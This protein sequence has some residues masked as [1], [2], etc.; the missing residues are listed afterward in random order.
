[1]KNRKLIDA[2]GY[3]DGRYIDMA[4]NSG[5]FGIAARI[6]RHWLPAAACLCAV[7]VLAAIIGTLP[8]G[9][10]GFIDDA[11]VAVSSG[12]T[13]A[14]TSEVYDNLGELLES[15]SD[16]DNH[17]GKGADGSSALRGENA[18]PSSDGGGK[19]AVSGGYAYHLGD[20]RVNISRLAGDATENVGSIAF[21]ADALYLCGERLALVQ[22]F[23]SGGDE[24]DMEYSVRVV[25]YELSDPASPAPVSEYTQLGRLAGCYV[26][27]D[28]LLLLT[29]D[30][31]CACGWSRLGDD[32]GYR[33]AL[34][35]DGRGADWSDEDISILGEPTRVNYVAATLFDAMS[36]ELI[37]RQALYGDIMQIFT[38]DGWLSL[39]VQSDTGELHTHPE[40]YMFDCSSGIDYSL[41]LS[42]AGLLGL[43]KSVRKPDYILPDGVYPSIASVSKQGDVYR[44][45]GGLSGGSSSELLAIAIDAKTGGCSKKTLDVSGRRACAYDDIIWE[46]SRAIASLSAT[47]ELITENFFV[48]AE[49][50]GTDISFYTSGLSADHVS[51]IDTMYSGGNVLGMLDAMIPLGEG[52]YLRYNDKPDGLDIFDFS[53]SANPARLYESGGEITGGR[54]FE[55]CWQVYGKAKF[56]VFVITPG[57]GGDYRSVG[58]SWR[59]YSVDARAAEPYTLL[60]EYD[61]GRSDRFMTELGD[62]L[63]FT[64]FEYGGEWYIASRCSDAATPVAVGK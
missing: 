23:V 35:L 36:C 2:V 13:G 62:A 44:I 15:L 32:S 16:N 4:E 40:L 28:R 49:F 59:I 21:E 31:A 64:S 53:D 54:R 42:T 51:G 14:K 7:A 39:L 52:I 45:L 1:M 30:G 48:V 11:P 12:T 25:I 17:E 38:G 60:A 33:P 34:T 24:L 58:W 22:S 61:L 37:D 8:R 55:F 6:R 19:A 63:A 18:T 3:I 56:G 20:G 47:P 41:R 9:G 46:E 29:S 10:G 43:E 50:S 27:G 26:R 5:G 57:D